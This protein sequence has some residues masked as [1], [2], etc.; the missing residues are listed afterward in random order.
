M[1]HHQILASAQHASN[2]PLACSVAL[3]QSSSAQYAL[4]AGISQLWAVHPASSV[5][6]GHSS[7]QAVQGG[8]G[9]LLPA[10]HAFLPSTSP[11]R[12]RLLALTAPEED[13]GAVHQLHHNLMML[14]LAVMQGTFSNQASKAPLAASHAHQAHSSQIQAS[15]LA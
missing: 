3:K 4:Q 10:W 8:Q 15:L 1:E 7:I 12:V 6:V 11:L 13:S 14:A 2:A 5:E 9:R